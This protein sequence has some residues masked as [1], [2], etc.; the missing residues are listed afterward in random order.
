MHTHT[1]IEREREKKKKKK[2]KKIHNLVCREIQ[3]FVL[4]YNF[5]NLLCTE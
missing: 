3:I 2:K 1:H 4:F 5:P